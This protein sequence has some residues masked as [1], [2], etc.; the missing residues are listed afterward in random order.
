MEEGGEE[1][2]E[3]GQERKEVITYIERNAKRS[4]SFVNFMSFE[5]GEAPCNITVELSFPFDR[6]SLATDE[7]LVTIQ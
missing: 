1:D 5:L 4:L 6:D 7:K 2:K 3:D